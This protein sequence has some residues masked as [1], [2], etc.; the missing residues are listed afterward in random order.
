MTPRICFAVAG[1]AMCMWAGCGG[2]ETS[3]NSGSGGNA[4]SGSAGSERSRWEVRAAGTSVGTG[5]S[6]VGF[7]QCVETP[8]AIAPDMPSPLGFSA[9]DVLALAGGADQSDLA[10]LMSDLYATHTR[11]QTQTSLT[12]TFA[13]QPIAVRFIDNQGGGCPGPGLGVACTVCEKQM[14]IDI[15]VT[16]VTGDGALN[17]KLS[18]TLRR[19]PRRTRFHADVMSRSRRGQL[20]LE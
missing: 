19:P 7:G 20:S 5:G 9:N 1:L 2:S 13:P 15:E 3:S 14:E 10:W 11:A 18:V 12:L 16:L 17:E 8:N 4:G 6:P